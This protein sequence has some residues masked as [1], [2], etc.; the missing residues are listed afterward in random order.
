MM[1]R[2]SLPPAARERILLGWS[3]EQLQRID[4]SMRMTMVNGQ[5]VNRRSAI[6]AFV[7]RCAMRA[8]WF[9]PGIVA[10]LT[11]Q[12]FG[13]HFRFSESANCCFLASK[14]GG[15]K[16]PQIWVRKMRGP[17]QLSDD[18][19]FRQRS[20]FAL[21]VVNKPN[22]PIELDDVS[23]LIAEAG[24]PP[25]ILSMD[26]VTFLLEGNQQSQTEDQGKLGAAAFYPCSAAELKAAGEVPING[27]DEKSLTRRL[28]P[29]AKFV[30]VRP[31]F[32]IHSIAADVAE[33]RRNA[34]TLLDLL[35]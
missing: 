1:E 29:R 27:Y 12:A 24:F 17:P 14:G 7:H 30:I 34:K 19:F 28:G 5:I 31:D 23:S 25:E 18:I 10:F 4:D 20:K 22:E 26:S 13:D 15:R 33:F 8:L 6:V 2:Q 32:F 21:I 35:L 11:Y 16:L 3:A 9:I